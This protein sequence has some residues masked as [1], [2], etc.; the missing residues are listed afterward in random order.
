MSIRRF[1]IIHRRSNDEFISLNATGPDLDLET[2]CSSVSEYYHTL[3]S[4]KEMLLNNP[5][6]LRSELNERIGALVDIDK[7]SKDDGAHV[8]KVTELD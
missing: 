2:K 5:K 3:Y 7:I 8:V 1:Y 6:I 4:I